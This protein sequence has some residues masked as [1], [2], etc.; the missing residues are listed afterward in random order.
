MQ[1][2]R[3]HST[4][5]IATTLLTLTSL[6]V[7]AAAADVLSD[8]GKT[9]VSAIKDTSDGSKQGASCNYE[10]AGA[11]G[12]DSPTVHGPKMF[13]TSSHRRAIGW[14]FIIE[15]ASPTGTFTFS[16]GVHESDRQV[17]RHQHV[18]APVPGPDLEDARASDRFLQGAHRDAVVRR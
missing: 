8:S 5:L 13:G 15:R 6:S 14:R 7:P 16:H 10:Q 11:G 12:I 18:R 9:G 1:L 17:D 2:S 3:F 4:I